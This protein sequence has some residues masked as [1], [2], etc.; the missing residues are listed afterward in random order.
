MCLGIIA[1]NDHYNFVVAQSLLLLM[2]PT[3]VTT[4]DAK[5]LDLVDFACIEMSEI[6]IS[7][8]STKC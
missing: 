5:C 2:I 3:C 7:Y 1:I 8:V 4:F 6:T